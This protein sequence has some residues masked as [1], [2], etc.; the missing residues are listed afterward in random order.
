MTAKEVADYLS[1]TGEERKKFNAARQRR[2]E[3]RKSEEWIQREVAR[4]RLTGL[5]ITSVKKGIVTLDFNR[6]WRERADEGRKRK[7]SISKYIRNTMQLQLTNLK[8]FPLE[9]QQRLLQFYIQ[10]LS[11]ALDALDSP[12]ENAD[13]LLWAIDYLSNSNT[14]VLL[15]KL[16]VI[17]NPP[18]VGRFHKIPGRETPRASRPPTP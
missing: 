6:A 14:D 13:L 9:D 11:K 10:A 7:G 12:I 8:A 18:R 1:L 4:L 16:M 17:D 5:P 3:E 2:M 15:D